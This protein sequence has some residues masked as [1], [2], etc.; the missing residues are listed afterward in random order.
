MGAIIDQM[1]AVSA[2]ELIRILNPKIQGW[3]N[4]YRHVAARRIFQHLDHRLWQKLWRW[5]K[6]RHSK[7][8]KKW[9]A[10]K[11]YKTIKGQKWR[12]VGKESLLYKYAMN[13][14][15][16]HI[17]IR[18]GKS[19]YDG[20][21]LYWGKRLTRGYGD[22][23]PKKAKALRVQNGK[24]EYCQATFKNGD[25]MEFHHVKSRKE[26]GKDNFNNLRLMH[27]HCHDQY[28]AQYLKRRHEERRTDNNL[29]KPYREMSD[30]QAE[31]MGIV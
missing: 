31:I 16:R 9:T 29:A 13:R 11:Y 15:Q 1:K 27:K 5:A 22:I 6:R 24:C 12:F 14:I 23:T 3:A 25:L 20:D 8:G 17:I 18:Q 19:V 30:I 4:Y 21:E 28:H 10:N 2:D 26:G 7:K